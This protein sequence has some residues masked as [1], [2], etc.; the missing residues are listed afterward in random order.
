MAPTPQ[1]PVT[2]PVT[3]SP[4]AP[5]P[6]SE[7][8]RPS[9]HTPRDLAARITADAR[10]GV[11]EERAKMALRKD[12]EARQQLMNQMR[13]LHAALSNSNDVPRLTELTDVVLWQLARVAVESELLV[14]AY[15]LGYQGRGLLTENLDEAKEKLKFWLSRFAKLF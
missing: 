9:L 6:A 7:P 15:G 13:Q 11:P 2:P 8:A 10:T 1:Q 14:R 4:V 12:P 5:P 3:P